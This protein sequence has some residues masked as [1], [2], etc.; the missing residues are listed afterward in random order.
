MISEKTVDAAKGKWRGILLALGVPDQYLTGKHSGCPLCH[1]GK[2]RFRF[3]DQGGRGTYFCQ[4][5]GAGDGIQFAMKFTGETFQT[6]AARIDGLLNN[7]KFEQ[8]KTGISSGDRIKML[9]EIWI[10]SRPLS[11][12]DLAGK[13]LAARGCETGLGYSALR[14]V[15]NLRDGEGG[16]RPCMIA[17]VGVFGEPK[18][19]AIHRTFLRPDGLAKAEMAAPRKL[20]AGSLTDGACVQ[21]GDYTGG[22]LGIAEGIETAISASDLFNVPVWAAI[23]TNGMAKWTPPPECREVLIFGDNDAKFGGQKSAYHLAHRLAV[24]GISVEVTIPPSVGTDWNDT[25]KYKK[26]LT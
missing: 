14:F 1:D 18:F 11:A 2:D 24:A 8:P 7:V 20:T 3:D 23:N 10:A 22:R 15:P 26:G 4:Q 21:L 13:Y 9:R 5:C 6:V 25:V 19:E 17:A 16:I 12:D